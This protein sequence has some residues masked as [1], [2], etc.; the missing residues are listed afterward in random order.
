VRILLA[1]DY[2]WPLLP[3]GAERV[4]FETSW[5]LASAG[6][7]VAVL[8]LAFDRSVPL[9]DRTKG[10]LICRVPAIELTRLIGLQSALSTR[11]FGEAHRVINEFRPDVVHGHGLFFVTTVAACLAA[12]VAGVPFVLS[13][14]IG[15][16]DALPV[17]QRMMARAFEVS[18]ARFMAC[19][20]RAIIAVSKAVE[21]HVRSLC[22]ARVRDKVFVVPNG[23][24]HEKFRPRERL[25]GETNFTIAFVGRLVANKGPQ[26]LIAAMPRVLAAFPRA[27]A[28][29]AGDGPL[30]KRLVDMSSR[31]RVCHAV[32][33]LGNRADVDE[34]LR[35]SDVF[36]RPSLS[37]G[38]P[39]TVLEAMSCGL[40][41]VATP[42]AGVPEV[43]KHGENGFLV[44]PSDP[45]AL[46][47]AIISLFEDPVRAHDMGL[48]G[49]RMVEG[50]YSW[51]LTT[52]QT[53]RVY[54]E[55]L[56]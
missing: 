14:H 26:F 24:D 11:V 15:R 51:D 27:R 3:G 55:I 31:L 40:P 49:R 47:D 8:T 6:H 18:I 54:R 45:R 41:V 13:A 32:E 16:L 50:H 1:S 25:P 30:R 39:L 42:I 10:V 19:R 33:F 2:Y 37:E 12:H 4:A 53:L 46:A 43:V 48:R 52:E 36:V 38:L 56:Q 22:G 5:R 35:K 29:I 17:T 44:P 28:V 7:D 34:I 21:E 9:G 20:A 23:V